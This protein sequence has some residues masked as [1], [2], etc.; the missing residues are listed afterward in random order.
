MSK[1]WEELRPLMHS[2][3]HGG[4]QNA[5]R[6]LGDGN[7][8]TPN[9]DDKE[10]VQLIQIVALMSFVILVELIDLSDNT[11]SIE[12]LNNIS[13]SMQQWALNK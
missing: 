10:V 1:I 2:Y 3:T 12:V 8:I 6:Q 7:Y 13:E 4:V 11:E 9:I 5:F